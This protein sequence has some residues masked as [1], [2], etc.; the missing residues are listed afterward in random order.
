MPAARFH[1]PH[2]RPLPRRDLLLTA[3]AA[4]A[5]W[6]LAPKAQPVATVAAASNLKFALEELAQGFEK[7]SGHKLRLVFGS[8]GQFYS[9]ILQGAPFHLFLSADESFALKLFEAKRT[10][11]R[12]RVYAQG[13]IG[14]LVPR[15]GPITADPEL[16]DLAAALKDGRLQRLAIANPE[17][18]PYGVLAVEALQRAGLYGAIQKHLVFGENVSQ[19]AQFALSGSTQG[20]IVAYSLALAPTIA[21]QSRFALID[22]RWHRPLLQRM[23]LLNHAPAA[24][25]AFYDHLSTPT[26]QAVM[27][28]HGF[29]LP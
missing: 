13:R 12:G 24:A 17:H 23:V 19:A 8:S 18:A 28:R 9:Q 2:V 26:A 25:K 27:Q 5:T 1:F 6:P 10:P 7:T 20:G 22:A 21:T 4:L 3:A 14:L 29:T 11:D 16:Q 15:N